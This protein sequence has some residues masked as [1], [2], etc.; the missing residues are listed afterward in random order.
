MTLNLKQNTNYTFRLL[1]VLAIFMIIDGHIG[2]YDYLSFNGIFPYQNYHIALFV[3]ASGYFI[4]FN[5]SYWDFIVH[6]FNKLILPLYLWN[7][8]YGGLCYYLNNYHGFS[9]GDG[10]T[11][12]NFLFAPIVDGHQFIYN[13]A[14]WFLVPLFLVQLISFI[15]LKPFYTAKNAFSPFIL[16]SYLIIALLLG[17]A[18]LYAASANEGQRTLV[19]TSLRTLYFLLFY[20]FGVIYHFILEKYDTLNTPL[21]LTV[22]I[23]VTICLRIIFPDCDIVPSWLDYVAAPVW[24]IYAIGILAILF[25][26]RIAKIF[27]PIIKESPALNYISTHTFDIMMHHFIGFMLVKAALSPLGSFNPAE[28]KQSIWYYNF[29]FG[30]ALTTP[31]YIIITLVI[32]LFIGFTNRQICIILGKA[33]QRLYSLFNHLLKRRLT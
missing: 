9:L 1:Y 6:K 18:A 10:F 12:Y 27:T 26:L 7:F 32:A 23:A 24:D 21:Y 16:Y 30:E 28:F 25:W 5:R 14:S 17:S 19:L 3:F 22:V 8:V 4:N 33:L 11:L 31:L 13:M 15:I 29:P 2:S 20:A